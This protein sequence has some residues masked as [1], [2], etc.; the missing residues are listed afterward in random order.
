MREILSDLVAE[1]QFLDQFLQRIG[2][3]DWER[4]TPAKGWSVRDTISHL[5]DSAELA[6]DALNG[7][8]RIDQYRTAPDLDT[9]RQ[10]AVKKGRKMRYQD[11]IEWW[12]GGRA[13]VVEPLSRMDAEQRIEWIA[14]SMKARTFATMR[15]METWAHGLDI[16]AAM[17]AE[18]EDTPRIRHICFLGWKTFPYA[19]KAA[20]LDYSPIRVEVIGPAYAKWVFGPTETDQMIKGPAGEFARLAV[21]RIK[22]KDAKNLKA[23]GEVAETALEVVRAY[24]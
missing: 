19:F 2:Q 13:K 14:G 23:S 1:Q 16:Y 17:K 21:R 11:V 24:L 5:A 20:D 10:E 3:K 22:R 4:P 18:I 6:A 15:L 12:R 9:L 8:N 7:G